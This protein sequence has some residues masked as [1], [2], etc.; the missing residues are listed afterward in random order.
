MLEEVSFFEVSNFFTLSVKEGQCAKA[1]E[2]EEK[3]K[4]LDARKG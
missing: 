4:Q 2:E 1:K 3:K